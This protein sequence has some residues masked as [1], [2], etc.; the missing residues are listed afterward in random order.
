M[1]LS[2]IKAR[3]IN[4]EPDLVEV[5]CLGIRGLLRVSK[6]RSNSATIDLT[7]LPLLIAKTRS[8]C[9]GRVIFSQHRY[10]STFLKISSNLQGLKTVHQQSTTEIQDFPRLSAQRYLVIGLIQVD[11]C[12]VR[13]PLPRSWASSSRCSVYLL[14][15]IVHTFFQTLPPPPSLNNRIRT[16]L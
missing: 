2:F 10:T 6:R 13:A 3:W 15:L 1:P 16:D 14:R 9:S 4:R 11:P 5:G 8:P 7:T 12:V